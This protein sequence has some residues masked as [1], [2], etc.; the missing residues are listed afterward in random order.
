LGIDIPED[1]AIS[2]LSISPKESL[3]YHKDPCLTKFIVVLFIIARNWKQPC[4][5]PTE[6]WIKKMWHIYT[7]E[8]YLAAKKIV[9]MKL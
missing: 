9:F 2:L 7:M 8:Y 6:E 5:P 3:P 4:C 1:L